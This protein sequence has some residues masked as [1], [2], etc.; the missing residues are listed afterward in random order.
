[1]VNLNPN[2][3][4]N[5]IMTPTVRAPPGKITISA[6][7]PMATPP[8]RVAFWISSIAKAPPL[9]NLEVK[10]VAT[11]D[12]MSDIMVLIK[13]LNWVVPSG[14]IPNINIPN[15]NNHTYTTI[16]M[17]TQFNIKYLQQR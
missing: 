5:P 6:T 2:V 8:A 11:A 17:L 9:S 1:M 12:P 13:A 3:E 14:A 10:N 7:A 4:T 16:D 15:S